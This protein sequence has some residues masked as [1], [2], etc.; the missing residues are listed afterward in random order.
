MI[1]W[2]ASFFLLVLLNLVFFAW[3]QGYFGPRDEG[4]EPERLAKQ[5]TPEKV[6]LV[7]G[8]A[9]SPTPSPAP[10]PVAV[11]EP[12]PVA[13]V[14][15]PA[16]APAAAPALVCRRVD[17]LPAGDVESLQAKAAKVAGVQW[18]SLPQA[19]QTLYWVNIPPLAGRPVA[20]KKLAELKSLGVA[21]YHLIETG[22]DALAI[23][24]GQFRNEDAAKTYLAAVQKKGVRSAQIKPREVPTGKVILE[25]RGTAEVIKALTAALGDAATLV[26]CPAGG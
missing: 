2:R 10:S 7:D 11:P 16:I 5:I 3:G 9:P 18:V 4:R 26:D 24:L 22:K 20:D 25:A 13:A 14:P 12:A 15:A 21:D 1:F 23:S 19:P 17:G 6:R 8:E